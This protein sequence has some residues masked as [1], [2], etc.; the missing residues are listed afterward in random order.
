MSTS[1]YI[2]GIG[3]RKTSVARVRITPSTKITFMVNDKEVKEYKYTG[4]IDCGTTIISIDL[5]K[6]DLELLS[7]KKVTK[8]RVC[9]DYPMD[10]DVSENKIVKFAES[11]KCMLSEF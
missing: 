11:I 1:K 7:S 8:I 10:Y 6:E 5:Q 3:R 2:E 9:F 4:K